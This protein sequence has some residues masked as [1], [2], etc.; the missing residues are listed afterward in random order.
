MNAKPY[1]YVVYPKSAPTLLAA[2]LLSSG[3]ISLFFVFPAITMLCWIIVALA[4]EFK[5]GESFKIALFLA[6][7]ASLVVMF[8]LIKI[9]QATRTA[10]RQRQAST[11]TSYLQTLLVQMQE[12]CAEIARFTGAARQKLAH[13]DQEFQARAYAPFWDV[14]ENI[15]IDISMCR[16][17]I[18]LLEGKISDY[19]R[20]LNGEIHTFPPQPL[21][22]NAIPPSQP[23]TDELGRLVRCGQTNFEFATIWEHRRTRQVIAEGFQTLGEAIDGLAEAVRQSFDRLQWTMS[24]GFRSVNAGLAKS[25]D[26]TRDH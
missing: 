24:A 19:T 11:K 13:A 25:A 8:I 3:A 21:D 1:A 6:A 5:A 2:E 20:Q 14:I 10:Y 16:T 18:N 4:T 9:S 22:M 23:L 26:L 7:V 17:R 12:T 15:A